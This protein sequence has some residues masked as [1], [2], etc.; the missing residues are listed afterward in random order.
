M[1]RKQSKRA[2]LISELASIQRVQA[3]RPSWFRQDDYDRLAREFSTKSAE[4]VALEIAAYNK[5]VRV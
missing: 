4:L 3:D 2:R 5:R 1:S